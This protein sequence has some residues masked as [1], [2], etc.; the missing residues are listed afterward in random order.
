MAASDMA[1]F[2]LPGDFFNDIVPFL[3]NF[4][5]LIQNSQQVLDLVTLFVVHY[6]CTIC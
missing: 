1:Y 4:W 3:A 6:H 5:S 2:I